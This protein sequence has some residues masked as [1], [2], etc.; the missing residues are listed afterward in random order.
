M[1]ARSLLRYLQ[2]GKFKAVAPYQTATA[3][4]DTSHATVQQELRR[5]RQVT[6]TATASKIF[7]I[8]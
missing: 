7:M 6:A 5:K 2:K 4:I 8:P 3:S 1:T